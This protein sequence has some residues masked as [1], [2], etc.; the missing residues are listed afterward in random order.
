MTRDCRQ[1]AESGMNASTRTVLVVDANA[2]LVT[3]IEKYLRRAG[4]Q[5][6]HALTG[7]AG[8]AWL[9]AHTADL[10]LL[11]LNPGDMTGE[12][13]L[14]AV[15]D[16]GQAV[17]FVVVTGHGEERRAVGMMKRGALDYLMKD[18]TLLE[19]LPA[20]VAQAPEQHDRRRLLHEAATAYEHLRRQ[21]EL[22][23]H[24]AGEGICGLDTQGRITF[25]NPAAL[26]LLG[27]EANELL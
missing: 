20:V 21:Y 22:I 6:E 26:R 4:F 10:L 23:L 25:I 8:L 13:F 19:L 15:E 11:D 18:G 9:T 1:G 12:Q 5:G 24:A 7:A 17:P 2:G 14:H 27:Y 3:L 16:R